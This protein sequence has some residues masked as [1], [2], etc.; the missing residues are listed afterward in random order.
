[1]TE[2]IF[3]IATRA[4][5]AIA[6]DTGEVAPASLATEGFVHCSAESQVAGSIER[7]F[8]GQDDLVL[9]RLHEA[10]V[11]DDLRWEEGRPG[12]LFP[13]VHRALRL[14]DVAEVLPVSR[15]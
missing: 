14:T 12:E 3:H 2:P 9:L 7:H 13:H 8:A 4:E 1:M 11:A 6:Q 15:P 5:W 10:A